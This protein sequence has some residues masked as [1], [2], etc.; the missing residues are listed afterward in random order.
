MNRPPAGPAPALTFLTIVPVRS[1]GSLSAS[2]LWFPVVGGLVGGFAGL[3]RAGGDSLVGGSAAAVLAT[4]AL[5]VVTGA[6]HQ[7]GLA[8]CAD[9]LGVRGNRERRLEVMRD[10]SNGTFATLALGL[11]LLGV[12]VALGGMT[13]HDAAWALV[14]AGAI[15]RWAALLHALVTR[16][17]RADGLG[18]SFAVSSRDFI[19]ASALAAAIAFGATGLA[20]AFIALAA[21]TILTAALTGW[22]DATLGGRTGDTLGAVVA[23]TEVVVLLLLLGLTTS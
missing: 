5:V 21:A 12:T 23:L 17:A 19:V 3:V 8:D 9:G 6:L 22:A 20:H 11:W 18:A 15:G 1:S 7:D 13:S 16:P 4:V 2:A 14:A 10:S